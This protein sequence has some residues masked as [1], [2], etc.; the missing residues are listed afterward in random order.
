MTLFFLQLL[1]FL[2]LITCI[3]TD[4]KPADTKPAGDSIEPSQKED[5]FPIASEFSG[6][7]AIDISKSLPKLYEEVGKDGNQGGKD[8]QQ[9]AADMQ[10][11]GA[12]LLESVS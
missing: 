8:Q 3:P 9:K 5:D 4:T 2:P 7:K 10:S 11:K 1:L 12:S 6:A